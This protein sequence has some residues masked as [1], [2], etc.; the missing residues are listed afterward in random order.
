M[1][2]RNLILYAKRTLLRLRVVNYITTKPGSSHRSCELITAYVKELGNY[3]SLAYI[4]VHLGLYDT[5]L[6]ST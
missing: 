6:N 3:N 4:Y 5:L 2:G 1:Q